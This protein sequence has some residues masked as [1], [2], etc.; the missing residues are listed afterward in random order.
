MLHH[1][2][3]PRRK[4]QALHKTTKEMNRLLMKAALWILDQVNID[5]IEHK[6][7]WTHMK[8]Q[9]KYEIKK[10]NKNKLII[11]NKKT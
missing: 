3:P 4:V 10:I 1:D 9:L 6:H 11:K 8:G 7:T 2:N 5:G